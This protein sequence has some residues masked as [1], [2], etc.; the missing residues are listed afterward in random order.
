MD[1]I[2]MLENVACRK[3][4]LS[5]KGASYIRFLF[6]L[7]KHISSSVL[8]YI[9]TGYMQFYHTK[10]VEQETETNVADSIATFI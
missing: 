5:D 1:R 2:R 8:S 3:M 10:R 9:N 4:F 7:A 6:S